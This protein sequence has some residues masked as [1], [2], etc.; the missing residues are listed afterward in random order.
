MNTRLVIFGVA[1]V[2]LLLAAL[3]LPVADW[4][5]LALSWIRDNPRISWA[6]FIALYIGATVLLLPG[7]ILTLGAGFAF[8]V[9]VGFVLVSFSSVVGA[10]A[11]FLIARF[12]A[13]GWA[14]QQMST[15]PRFRALDAAV[16]TRG[17]L[18]VFLTRL[19]PVFPFN[20]Q[21]YAYGVTRV[22]FAHYVVSSWIGMI[23]GTLLYVYLGSVAQDLASL[24]AGDLPESSAGP[25]L[26][27]GGLAATLAVT[28]VVTRIATRALNAQ[29]DEA[30]KPAEVTKR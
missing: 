23:P 28:L 18:I 10:S 9:P 7:L 3:T 19:S 4:L 1:L 22:P 5:A 21:N 15:M 11:A 2:L 8:G 17:W 20:L 13:R 26:F 16:G 25:W 6:V 29:L 12:F 27:Y 24:A 14:E 30:G